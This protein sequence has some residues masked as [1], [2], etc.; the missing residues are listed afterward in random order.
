MT[1]IN[2]VFITITSSLLLLFGLLYLLFLIEKN[3]AQKLRSSSNKD[4]I[5]L[6][7]GRGQPLFL[8]EWNDEANWPWKEL[9]Y[10]QDSSLKSTK[11]GIVEA[12]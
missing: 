12:N 3:I 8:K 7:F 1:S 11:E 4:N 5:N 9:N 10:S 6:F 2:K